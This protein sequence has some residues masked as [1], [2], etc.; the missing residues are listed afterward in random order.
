MPPI[1]LHWPNKSEA[2]VGGM[3]VEFESSTNILLHDVA[4]QTWQYR[5]SLT[6]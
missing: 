4:V 1:L 5:G 6:K 3:A 2:D